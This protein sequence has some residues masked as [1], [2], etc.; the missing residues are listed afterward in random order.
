VPREIRKVAILGAGVMGAGIAAHL[1]NV[2]IPSYLLDIVPR[3]LT[4]EEKKKGLTLES[5]EVRNRL[6]AQGVQNAL[7]S[8]PAAFHVPENA[9]LITVGNFEDNLDWCSEVDWII[10]VII[11]KLDIKKSLL[12]KV[13]KHW[14]PGTIVSTNTSGISINAMVEDR[15]PEFR[16]HFLGTHFFN[17]PRYM[18]LLEIIPGEETDPAI[19]DFIKEFGETVL[20]KGIVMCK[21]TPNFIANRLGVY[22]M[23]ECLR[24]TVEEGY[25]VEEVDAI[26]GRPMGRPKSATFRTGDI[27][28]LDT[29]YH[30]ATNV[31]ESLPTPEAKKAFET[32][33][34]LE[35]LMKRKWL[36]EKTGQGFYKKVKRPDGSSEILALDLKTMEYAPRKKPDLASLKQAKK[37]PDLGARMKMLVSADDRAG[38]FIW[39]MTKKSLLYAASVAR[40]ISDDIYSIDNAMK[41]G[42]NYEMG[43]FETWDAIGVQ[44][45][46]S[47][48][49][50][51]GLEVADWVKELLESGKTSFYIEKDGKKFY[52][53]WES[54]DYK[55]MPTDP[56]MFVLADVKKS[57]GVVCGNTDTSLI[58]LG[59]GVALLE[60]HSQNQAIGPGL[61]EGIY[62]A[63]EEVAKPGWKGLVVG[64]QAQ[65]FCVGANLL[66]VVMYANEGKYEEIAQASKAL[67]DALMAMKYFPKP[68]VTAP[69]SLALGGGAE[70]IMHGHRVVAS[71]ETYM[72]CVEFGVGLLPAGGGCK[73]LLLRNLEGLPADSQLPVDPMPAVARAFETIA[74]AKV[75]T[76]GPEAIKLGYMRRSDRVV[77]N[78]DLQ[79]HQAKMEVLH[80]ADSGFRPPKPAKIKVVGDS[81]RAAL[82]GF[83]YGMWKAGYITAHDRLIAN[84]IAY[85]LTGGPA[86]PGTEV[87]EQFIL[88]LEREA[89]VE[90]CREEKSRERMQYMLMNNK[91]LR[92]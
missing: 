76:S 74:M 17:P 47:R 59:D 26:T 62:M 30:V 6:A 23:L 41:W 58:D 68:V 64:N 56:R 18:K 12:E 5:P 78:R 15:S 24:Y 83:T 20:G 7:K 61:I 90:L 48:M 36:G 69:H 32:P 50:A 91:P 77:M 21:D 35:E 70:I 27:V 67:Q 81:G 65:N 8:R 71:A 86:L 14:K 43:P 79:F 88:D 11:E 53:D 73:E 3:E 40:E 55:P 75:S 19:V 4:E 46:V 57:K 38:R 72:G 60:F 89:F 25:T 2:G 87:T 31:Y 51:E 44:E 85:V 1:A 54:R 80:M 52:Y 63:L 42:F 37:I 45:T 33:P 34:I 49:A 39:E 66:M 29:L 10:E 16:R 13:E 9:D 28:G 84:K 22:G 92:N 82:E